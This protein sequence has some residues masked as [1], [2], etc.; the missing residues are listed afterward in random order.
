V[1]VINAVAERLWVDWVNVARL[2]PLL[3]EAG[4]SYAD[5][6]RVRIALVSAV[7]ARSR[8]KH[9]RVLPYLMT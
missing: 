7:G 1:D 9:A 8:P 4:V 2:L 3:R 6:V 5:A